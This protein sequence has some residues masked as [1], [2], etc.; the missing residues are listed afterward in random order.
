DLPR[1]LLTRSEKGVALFEQGAEEP[2]LIQ[3][4]AREV[5]DVSGAGDTVVAVLAAAVGSGLAW[6]RASWL[7]NVAAG[8]AVE[9]QGTS[10]VSL[11]EL[12]DAVAGEE[13]PA[14]LAG[15][16]RKICSR[17]RLASLVASWRRAGERIVFTN[18]CFDLL[19]IGHVHVITEAARQGDRLIVAVN[20]DS[21]VRRLKGP[22][23]PVQREEARAAVVAALDGVDAVVIFGE[24]TPLALIEAVKPD[25]LV[26][27]GDYTVDTVV[28][29]PQVLARG[30]RVHLVPTLEGYSTTSIIST[31][32]S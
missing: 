20:S 2:L 21:S 8:V 1:I 15:I 32:T 27:G 5:A 31:I 13:R 23:R 14:G 19:H 25:V 17:E 29:A 24:D 22:Q 12:E 30:G 4:R 7:A 11:A 28:G 26:K 18:G 9:K 16:E 10:T 6:H 3:G